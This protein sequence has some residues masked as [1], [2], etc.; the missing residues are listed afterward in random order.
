MPNMSLKKNEM[1]AQ[2]PDV[3]NKNFKEVAL[4]YTAETAVDEAKRCLNC[5]HKPCVGGCPVKIHIPDFIAKVAEGKFEEAYQI[6]Q[7]SSSLP[8]VCGRVCPQETQCEQKCVRGVKGEP[9]AIGRLER[10]VADW[11]NEHSCDLPVKAQPNGHK[12][13]VV[14]SGPAGL[15]CAG[16]LAK[17]GYDVTVF[18]ALHLAGGVLVYGIPEFRLPKAIV[19]KEIDNLNALGVKVETNMVIGKVLSVDELMD[20]F[21]FEAVFIGSGAGLPRFMN[22]P[23]ENLKDVYSANEF[24]TR[25]NLMKAY[26]EDARTPIA[27]AKKVAVVG[28]GNVA[29]DAARCAKR[30]GAE[31]VTIVYRRSEAELPARREEVEHAKEE[32]ISFKL[33]TNPVR[34]LEGE[35]GFVGGMEC[36]EME[37]GEPDASGRR[38]PVVK[39]NSEF[40]MDVD[41]VIM[42]IGTSPNPLIKSTTKGLET[43]RWGGIIADEN[44][45]TSRE[46]VFAGGDAV[47]VAATVILAMGAGKTA[48]EAIDE[49]IKNKK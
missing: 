33:L 7:K 31:E 41:C 27:H 38:S 11:H 26:K 12:V 23:G 43:Q 17:R 35:N 25:V 5:K 19:Q 1:P 18:E 24:L 40:T 46:G 29:M 20:E 45:Q 14:G 47:T 22:I 16:D 28:G 39:E 36:V 37:L 32:G 2:A 48:A 6:I 34:I 49:Y 10:F 9:V 42:A 8:A 30:L 13:A 21:A 4:G 3:R 15:T 44:G